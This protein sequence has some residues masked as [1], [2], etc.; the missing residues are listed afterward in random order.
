YGR[1]AGPEGFRA[2]GSGDGWADFPGTA[3]ISAASSDRK[4]GRD[5]RGPG[6]RT[7]HAAF[8]SGWA[9]DHSCPNGSVTFPY[10]SPQNMSL[11]GMLT[12]A[13]AAAARAPAASQS[14]TS[15]G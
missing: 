9:N 14:A 11:A 12:V 5:S 2:V 8:L 4:G 3:A 1:A 7:G 15:R 6:S 10:R 13:P